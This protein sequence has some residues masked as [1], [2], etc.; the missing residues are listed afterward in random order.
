MKKD[1][2]AVPMGTQ[3]ET[4]IKGDLASSNL[5]SPINV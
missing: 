2:L 5:Q 4:I 1:G 3:K